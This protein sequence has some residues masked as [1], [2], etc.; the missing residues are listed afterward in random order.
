LRARAAVQC[1]L[2]AGLPATRSRTKPAAGRTEG[3]RRRDAA[4]QLLR[5]RRTVLVRRVQRACLT[6]LLDGRPSTTDPIRDQVPI[7]TG[8]DP[9]LVGAAVRG[10]AEPQLI[11]RAGLSRSSRPEAHGRDLPLWEIADRGAV[12]TWLAAHPDLPEA[13][14][15]AVCSWEALRRS[16]CPAKLPT[17]AVLR[18]VATHYANLH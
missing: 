18:A 2:A 14:S 9:R 10:L 15:P 5:D 4:L 17:P 1:Q 7:P 6:L 8:I 12:L 13:R 11:R 3:E 16:I